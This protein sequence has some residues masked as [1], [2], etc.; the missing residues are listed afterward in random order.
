MAEG[1]RADQQAGHDLVA[2]AEHQRA[3]EHVVPE[4][5]GGAIA[6]T[7]RLNSESSMPCATLRDAVAHGGHAARDLRDATGRSTAFLRI[8]G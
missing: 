2:D 5:D 8:E 1:Q 3:V 7:S 4:R 6:T